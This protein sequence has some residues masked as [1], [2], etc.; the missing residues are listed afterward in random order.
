M[1]PPTPILPASHGIQ[2]WMRGFLLLAFGY[3]LLWGVFI[4]QWPDSFYT[5]VQQKTGVIEAPD[6]ITY[7]GYGVLLMALV[8]LVASMRP[9]KMWYLVA[10]GAGTKVLGALGFWL[11]IMEQ[12]T[13]KRFLFHLI[14]NDLVWVPILAYIAWKGYIGAKEAKV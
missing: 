9:A 2:P 6:L 5:W 10:L 8:Y 14:F 7:Q 4:S 12:A 13:T 11:L 1:N 3:N